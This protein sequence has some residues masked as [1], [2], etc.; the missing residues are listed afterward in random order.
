MIKYS[1]WLRPGPRGEGDEKTQEELIAEAVEAATAALKSKNSELLGKQ[2]T[3][4]DKL[5]AW[6]DLDP[7]ATRDLVDKFA[8]NEELRLIAD[9]KHDEVVARRVEREKAKFQS[10]I[11]ELTTTATTA[12]TELERANA[13][14]KELLIDGNAKDE[15]VKAGGRDTALDDIVLRARAAFTLEDGQLVARDATGEIIRGKSGPLTISE[16]INSKLKTS[17]PHLFGETKGSGGA[18]GSGDSGTDDLDV[19]LLAAAQ[20]GN[21]AE[22]RK[23]RDEQDKKSKAK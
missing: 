14:I 16:W 17:A 2:K 10:Q 11:D 18:G 15:F 20:S 22:Y 6:G 4:Q 13:K 9:G 7:V 8:N 23:L 5:K 3:F 12:N 21:H 1:R 19:R